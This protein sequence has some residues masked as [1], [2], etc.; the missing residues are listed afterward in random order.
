MH[1]G[2]KKLWTNLPVIDREVQMMQS[3]MSWSVDVMLEPSPGYHIRIVD[4]EREYSRS[5]SARLIGLFQKLTKMLQK[6][7]RTNRIRY[8]YRCN[9]N[10]KINR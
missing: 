2:K 7:T 5:E 8:K 10:M 6:L 9:G 1:S 4:L 3:M